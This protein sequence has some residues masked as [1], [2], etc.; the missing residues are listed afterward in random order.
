MQVQP[1]E[2]QEQAP[3]PE[4]PQM[5]RTWSSMA[6]GVEAASHCTISTD[7]RSTVLLKNTLVS[8]SRSSRSLLKEAKCTY[9]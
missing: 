6:G 2:Q 9:S 7:G 3:G 4:Q 8:A 1:A 5:K